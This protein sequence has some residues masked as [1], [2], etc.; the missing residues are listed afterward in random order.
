MA[1]AV[2]ELGLVG[3][4]S[5]VVIIV[6]RVITGL[7]A[8]VVESLLSGCTEETEKTVANVTA[9]STLELLEHWALGDLGRPQNLSFL[10][11]F[12]TPTADKVF[13]VN[14]AYQTT[15]GEQVNNC[16]L[17]ISIFEQQKTYSPPFDLLNHSHIF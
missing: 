13:E 11:K 5:D 3:V 12:F 16:L 2:S 7:L 4:V 6:V 10:R 14:D 17:K 9:G 8:L 1:S 15:H